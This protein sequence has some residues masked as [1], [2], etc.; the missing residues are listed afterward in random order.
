MVQGPIAL[1]DLERFYGNGKKRVKIS[2]RLKTEYFF[3]DHP[4][5][6]QPHPPNG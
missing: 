2:I 6:K 5:K 3:L 1:S 4:R